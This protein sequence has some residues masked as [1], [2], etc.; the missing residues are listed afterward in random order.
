MEKNIVHL[1]DGLIVLYRRKNSSRYQCRFRDKNTGKWLRYSCKS[2]DLT[3]AKEKAQEL[4][5]EYMFAE[6]FDLNVLPKKRITGSRVI[7]ELIK[8][9]DYKLDR[10]LANKWT[11]IGYKKCL[12]YWFIP[13]FGNLDVKS[14]DR[15][16]LLKFDNYRKEKMGRVPAKNTIRMHK[17]LLNM[18]FDK[19]VEKN[20]I[21]SIPKAP[22]AKGK[23]PVPRGSF[24]R[25]EYGRMIYGLFPKWIAKEEN[26]HMQRKKTLLLE[27]MIFLANTGVRAGTEVMNIKFSDFHYIYDKMKDA[28]GKLINV[29]Y[30]GCAIRKGKTGPRNII[31]RDTVDKY[32]IPAIQALYPDLAGLSRAK[33]FKAD[34]LVFGDNPVT[35]Q[36]A[37]NYRYQRLFNQFLKD[38]DLLL[39]NIGQKRSLYS[40]RHSWVSWILTDP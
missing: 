10:G 26:P 5:D 6:K 31:C 27:L 16:T 40:L 37:S 23:K 28:K 13:F 8:D 15:K 7:E 30:L 34:E 9:L 39:D 21:N 11:L 18:F 32:T 29:K 3:I 4:Y 17:V 35:S 20:W 25:Q 19:A 24:T 1:R 22:T 36:N 2:K 38:H 33:L 14:I 12:N